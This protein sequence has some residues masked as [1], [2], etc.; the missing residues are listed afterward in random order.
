M[1]E[2]LHVPELEPDLF[3]ATRHGKRE[4]IGCSFLLSDGRMH[5]TFPRF[6]IEREIPNDNAL[7]VSVE[8]LSE[9]DL[10]LP[11]GLCNGGTIEDLQLDDFE[12]R[13][14]YLN[15]VFRARHSARVMTRAQKK[16]QNAE[17]L[18]A[19]GTENEVP[20]K[21]SNLSQGDLNSGS[22]SGCFTRNLSGDSNSGSHS[23]T[24]SDDLLNDD[25]LPD[26]ISPEIIKAVF[27]NGLPNK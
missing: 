25:V 20:D 24:F 26:K 22:T 4:N 9:R 3:S 8:V 15:N 18:K 6:S 14:Y 27:Q 5:L 16:R 10:S 1:T 11:V 19:L 2:S 23:G 17:L 13:L 12:E 7:S 21:S